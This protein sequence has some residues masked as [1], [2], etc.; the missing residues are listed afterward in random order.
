TSKHP[1]LPARRFEA[2]MSI[3]EGCGNAT[4]LRAIEQ[5]ELHQVW[6]VNLLDGIFFFA[7]GSRKGAES[8]RASGIFL[9]NREHEGAIDFVEAMLI[10]AQHLQGFLCHRESDVAL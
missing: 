4:A 10:H 1:R 5:A 8:H 6:F 9:Q 2:E 3:G 7:A